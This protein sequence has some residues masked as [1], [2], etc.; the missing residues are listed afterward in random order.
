MAYQLAQINLARLLHPL[1]DPR[2][3]DF[4]DGLEPIN[5][6]ADDAPGFV[7][8]LKS[9][10]GNATDLQHPWSSDP[11]LLVNMSVW[12]LPDHLRAFTYRSGHMEFFQRRAEWF[13]KPTQP[14]YVLWWVPAGHI[15]T[16]EE[17]QERLEHYRA[18]G[19]TPHAFWFGKLFPAPETVAAA[20]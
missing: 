18:N 17:A 6:L 5:A 15:P 8:R 10:T 14:H 4:V 16:L 9:D 7:W 13:E 3:R 1:D 11:F 12:E 20:R 19:A 2:I